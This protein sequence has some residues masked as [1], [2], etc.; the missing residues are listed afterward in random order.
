[1]RYPKVTIHV[2][3]KNARD[4][5]K[6]CID[7]LL[8]LNYPSK[9]IWVSDAY[10]TDG[11]WEILERYK[12]KIKFFR[13]KG[14]A[15]KAHNYVI[16]KVKTPFLAFTD[17]DCVVDKNWLRNLIN[18]FTS[19]DI[20]ATAGYCSTPKKVNWLQKL[21]G[22][23]LEARFKKHFKFL[24]HAPTMN[25]CVRT[26]IA[27]KVK[28][29]EKLDVAF[30]TDWGFR[31]NKYGKIKYVPNAKIY[32]YHRSTLL[33]Y[34]KQ[35][36]NQAKFTPRVYTKDLKI[37]M[38]NLLCLQK[39]P[40]S[41]PK[42]TL[43]IELLSLGFLFLLLTFFNSYFFFLALIV[44]LLLFTSYL[45]DAIKLSKS[46]AEIISFLGLFFFRNITWV[47]GIGTGFLSIFKK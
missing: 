12:R 29:D 25:F 17:A 3:V 4:T 16:R 18:G 34:L 14:N 46:S 11:T 20:I 35:Q 5:I 9:E 32:H 10:S 24:P 26:K 23:E 27:K 22:K 13:I 43:Q 44:F 41:N 33:S 28:L 40:I 2:T 8:R 37:F 1:M 47:F 15:P 30:E 21:I 19:K 6:K 31:L 7:S 42:M 39:D 45:N 38:K 36:F